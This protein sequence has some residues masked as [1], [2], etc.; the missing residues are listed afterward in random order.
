VL[1]FVAVVEGTDS[2][3]RADRLAGVSWLLGEGGLVEAR[4]ATSP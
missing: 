1:G 2:L 3:R 4:D